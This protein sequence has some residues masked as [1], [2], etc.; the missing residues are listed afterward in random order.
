ME[1]AKISAYQLFALIILFEHGSAVL[2]PVAVGAGRDAWIAVILGMVGGL[3]IVLVS[4]LLFHYYP[5]ELPSTYVQKILGKWLGKTVIIIYSLFYLFMSSTNLRN[6]GEMLTDVGYY[7]TPLWVLNLLMI[8]V[9]MYSLRNGIEV[10]SRTGEIF[11]MFYGS[12]LIL[13]Y[14]IFVF[15]N[16]IDLKNLLP[17]LE[18]GW[19]P[20]IK[21][22]V[23]QTAY[24]PFG[25]A[26]V[27]VGVYPYVK[28]PKKVKT[29]ALLGMI[30]SG[31][32]LT[33]ITIFN[34]TVLGEELLQR[35]IFPLLSTIQSIQ[36]Q[37]FIV[38]LDV[39]FLLILILGIYF[40]ITIFLY[41]AI[42]FIAEIFSIKK[43][44]YLVFPFSFIV[45]LLSFGIVP[46]FLSHTYYHA[47]KLP[48]PLYL[49][50][51]FVMP[52]IILLIAVFKNMK[53]KG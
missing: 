50:F 3:V 24:I 40:R 46:T 17:I 44:T 51:Q 18:D 47:K 26:V 35:T 23:T 15:S 32:S 22:A 4:L 34:I 6:L 42:V 13:L 38:R 37:D 27:L 43:M 28:N 16:I 36:I 33:L 7:R 14:I 49:P 21:T 48:I 39:F 25:G 12:I 31:I 45:Y 8:F 1:K 53:K 19:K 41:V 10:I 9:V 30:I 52:L 20:V 11:L 2:L 29:V 5:N